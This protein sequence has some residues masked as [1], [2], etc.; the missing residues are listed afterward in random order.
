MEK[1]MDVLQKRRVLIKAK[2]RRQN[3]VKL[4]EQQTKHSFLL[5]KNR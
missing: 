1:Y 5:F 3:L 4:S 2:M